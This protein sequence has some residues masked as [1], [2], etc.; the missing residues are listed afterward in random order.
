M[1]Y[2]SFYKEL[3]LSRFAELCEPHEWKYM[4]AAFDGDIDAAGM[5]TATLRNDLRGAVAVAMWRA[6]IKR[7]AFREYFSGVWEHDHRY[8]IAAA[9]PATGAGRADGARHHRAGAGQREPRGLRQRAR[10]GRRAQRAAARIAGRGTPCRATRTDAGAVRRDLPDSRQGR[11]PRG[12][13]LHPGAWKSL[14]PFAAGNRP[15]SHAQIKSPLE[16]LSRC[17]A[18]PTIIRTGA[19]H[20][21]AL[22]ASPARRCWC[23]CQRLA[24]RCDGC[25]PR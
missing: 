14:E 11:Q 16:P 23:N 6:K 18:K 5:L 4:E 1:S 12:R 2:E 7:E 24:T 3:V 20:A 10:L 19:E 8:A 9:H 17:H 21:Q 13:H 22:A 15:V 25:W